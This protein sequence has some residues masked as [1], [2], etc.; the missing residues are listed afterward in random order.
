[1]VAA[2]VLAVSAA[3]LAAMS[4][5][6]PTFTELVD[7]AD[8]I[9]RGVVTDVHSETIDTTQG[10]AIHTLVTLHVEMVLKGSPGADVTLS[11]LGG[12]VGRRTLSVVGMPRFE[13][14]Q[15]EIVFVSRNGQS[16]CPLVAAGHG[17]YHV[18]HDA[19]GNRDYVARDNNAPLASAE[20]VS[21]ALEADIAAPA[22]T[23]AL[24]QEQFEQRVLSTAQ[25]NGPA[26]QR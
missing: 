19:A 16:I 23:Q 21:S 20:D 6:P 13:V 7:S 24:S 3:G 12:K 4:V 11:F 17:R 15:R 2:T 8:F 9:A 10:P 14:G 22:P 1:V 18:R 25:R 5:F 26:L